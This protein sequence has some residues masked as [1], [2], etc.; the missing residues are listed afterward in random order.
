VRFILGLGLAATLGFATAACT[1]PEAPTGEVAPTADSGA[2][3]TNE[4]P[5][6]GDTAMT[7]AGKIALLLPETKT[8][9]YETQDRPLFEAKLKEL[10]PTCELIY[11]NANQD[12]ATQQQ[13]AEAALTNGAQVL[14]L[15]PVDS[16]A[17]GGIATMAKEQGVPVVSYD[18]L[19]LDAPIDYYISFDNEKV[20]TLQGEALL[21]Q[22]A[23]LGKTSGDLVMINGAP[24]D[25]NAK[26]FKA[27][28]HSA[29]DASGFTIGAEYDTPDWSPDKAQAQM[30]QAITA[31]GKAAIV[32]V[33]AADHGAGR[34]AGRHPAHPGQR[35]VHD[36][37]QGHQAGS[38]DRGRAGSRPLAQVRRAGRY[39]LD[40][41]RQRQ[42][43]HPVRP[44]GAGEG[45]QGQRQ[46]HCPQGCV[47]DLG[48]DLHDRVCRLLQ[49]GRPA[50]GERRT[51]T[52][53]EGSADD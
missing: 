45:D 37:V 38:R 40:E 47:L 21:E 29:L 41:C 7:E 34:R 16:K 18:R 43:R 20:G 39:Q 49:G 3:T 33:L 1:A 46:G 4:T 12:A 52:S 28:A 6:G 11:S 14:V 25:N 10:C 51:T 32:G 50:V 13:Q 8:A 2:A 36:R 35:A 22:L 48:A 23:A 42:R 26:M 30:E 5:A 17:A 19:I 24:T 53:T 15:D 31:L 44:A 27:G 9:R